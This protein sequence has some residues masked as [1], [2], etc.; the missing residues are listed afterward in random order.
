VNEVINTD[1]SGAARAMYSTASV[2]NDEIADSCGTI[3]FLKPTMAVAVKKQL[4]LPGHSP[5]PFC[6]EDRRRRKLPRDIIQAF[7]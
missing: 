5:S 1:Q 4:R 7:L 3:L 2:A 6:S